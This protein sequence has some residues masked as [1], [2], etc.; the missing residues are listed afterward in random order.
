MPPAGRALSQSSAFTSSN[1]TGRM[2]P[3]A[4]QEGGAQSSKLPGNRE[5]ALTG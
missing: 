4:R 5:L 1:V 3:A 2:T